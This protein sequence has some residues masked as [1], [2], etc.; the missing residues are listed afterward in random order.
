M[1]NGE[2][3]AKERSMGVF[4]SGGDAAGMNA[5]LRAVTRVGIS[6][7]Y[8]VF[9]IHE[10]Y[11]GMVDGGDYFEEASW[12]SVSD[13]IQYSGTIIGSARCKAFKTVEGRQ[14]AVENLV[15]HGITDLVCIGGDG[16]L[17][18]LN[19]LRQEWSSHLKKLVELKRLDEAQV[20]RFG[21][22]HIVG[23]VGS[24][25][26]DFCGTDMTIGVDSAL[27]RIV[28]SI[29]AVASTAQSHQRTFVIEVMGRR[30]GYL[31]LI[32]SIVSEADWVFTPEWPVPENWPQLLCKKLKE[33]R[34]FG[35]RV[36]I[37]IC[38]E[39]ATDQTGKAIS[40]E[41]VRQVVHDQLGYDTRVTV[42]GHV[43]RGGVPS[44]FDRLLA[45]RMGADA[46]LALVDANKATG[47]KEPVVITL[48]GNV[49]V[50]RSLTKCVE[51]TLEVKAALDSKDWKRAIE[52]RGKTFQRN[53]EAYNLLSKMHPP[54]DKQNLSGGLK[55]NL[56]VM[57]VGSPSCGMNAAV[58]CFVRMGL[59][60]GCKVYA[61]KDSF[62]GLIKGKLTEMSW[63]S[64]I[65]WTRYG[66]SF[67]GSQK[68]LP[69]MNMPAVAEQLGRYKINALLLVGGFEAYHACIE[70]TEN[71]HRFKE[72]CIPMAV[73]PCT[74]SNNVPG[75]N[76][77]IG[78]DT[79]LNVICSM[80][81]KLKQS[82]RGTKHRVFIVET[83]GGYCGYLATLAG[84]ASGA[85]NAYIFEQSFGVDDIKNDVNAIA[86][87]MDKGVQRYIVTRC[88]NANKHYTTE[89][90]LQL[91]SEEGKGQ[92]STRI[93]VLGHAQQGGNASP[94]DRL[95]ATRMAI[96]VAQV[97]VSMAREVATEDGSVY[98]DNPNTA[99]LLGVLHRHAQLTP[100][101]ELKERTD[102][103]HRLPMDQWWLKL[104]PLL[105]LLAAYKSTYATSA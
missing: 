94:F 102:F 41:Q 25:D 53:F 67:L 77:S 18:G 5:A 31:A 58:R 69:S 39:G 4:T 99:L 82:A 38:A 15:I 87:K 57:N 24:I 21:E 95:M 47:E 89:F 79:A 20:D 96:H 103:A 42:L 97:L 19:I 37:I 14:R 23:L 83:M 74:I 33:S 35:Q 2:E 51:Q 54:V 55:F 6:N 88:E 80:V 46:V 75:A 44:A 10:G 3:K 70:L 104:H 49:L 73:I 40:S 13:I 32:A 7:G 81:D 84:L 93:N 27:N 45:S 71:R 11:Q 56:A 48:D 50:R 85:D 60:H 22:L 17:T 16:S 105:R 61:I 30:C 76:Y 101:L 29:D 9:L 91:F 86:Q 66:G 59:Y 98:T 64:V 43:Q 65:D 92:F 68:S 90:M 100:V 62:Q 8:R 72:F 12:N 52:L 26:N 34:D 1:E 36:N 78:S 63:H 28:E